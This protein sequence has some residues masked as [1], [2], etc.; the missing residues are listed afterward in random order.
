MNM[1]LDKHKALRK[2]IRDYV[3]ISVAMIS[4]DIS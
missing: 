4:Y 1:T 3:M 2:E